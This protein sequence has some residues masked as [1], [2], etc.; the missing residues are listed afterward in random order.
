MRQGLNEISTV[1]P[2]LLEKFY[3]SSLN[4]F[5]AFGCF[6]IGLFFILKQRH[7]L[8][9]LALLSVTIVFAF[10]ILKTGSVFPTHSYY[11]VPFA[12][13][14]ALV[15]S[16]FLQELPRKIGLVVL[17][18]IMIEGIANQQHDFFLRDSE[19]YKLELESTIEHVVPQNELVVINGGTTPQNMYFAH[20]KGWPIRNAEANPM[21]VDSLIGKGAKFLIIDKHQPQSGDFDYDLVYDDEHYGVYRLTINN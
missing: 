13:V 8:L 3:F 21:F 9:Q 19:L 11:I 1:L 14:M 10:F 4:S 6:L 20:R 15:V 16:Y 18:I 17:G 2:D 5:V 12:P 7:R